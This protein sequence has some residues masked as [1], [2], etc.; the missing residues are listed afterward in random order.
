MYIVSLDF[1]T[2]FFS[3]LILGHKLDEIKRIKFFLLLYTMI[4][5]TYLVHFRHSSEK[6]LEF[7]SADVKLMFLFRVAL[8]SNN[9]TRLDSLECLFCGIF[10]GISLKFIKL[11][12][13]LI[14]KNKFL[15]ILFI[16]NS[17]I[18]FLS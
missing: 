18:F 16:S 7:T 12:T 6:Q 8:I 11:N 9:Y 2:G 4:N 15:Y 10:E 14:F 17:L 3:S 13:N 5:C 1:V